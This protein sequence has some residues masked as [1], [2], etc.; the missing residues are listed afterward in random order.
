[1][2]TGSGEVSPYFYLGVDDMT[3]TIL[4]VDDESKV[5]SAFSRD[6]FELDICNVLTAPNGGVGLEMV[7]ENP[8]IAAVFSDFHMPGLD[9]VTF[10]SEVRKLNPDITRVIITGAAGLNM[11]L[12]AINIGQIFRILLKPTETDVFIQTV[13]DAIR[14]YQLITSEKVL[15]NK[16]LNGAVKTLVDVLSL[17]SPEVFAQGNRLRE[18]AKKMARYFPDELGWEAELSALL[19]QIGCVTVPRE[20]L[21]R[22]LNG[23]NLPLME[24]EMIKSIPE[25]GKQ[26]IENIP[27][28]EK[29]A[30]A[31][32]NQNVPYQNSL[33]IGSKIYHPVSRI[34]YLLNLLLQYD[35]NLVR[36]KDPVNAFTALDKKID[37]FDPELFKVFREKVIGLDDLLNSGKYKLLPQQEE[38]KVIDLR[39]GAVLAKEIMDKDGHMVVAKGTEITEVLKMR[40]INFSLTHRINPSAWIYTK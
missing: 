37:E 19:C 18:M 10:L 17:F 29:V 11:A 28:M 12:D 40:L 30:E 34:A 36:Y 2:H 22:W 25:S 15:L 7:R 20:I 32:K 14:Q 9:G 23:E 8:E 16:T 27:R 38:V 6:I 31:I 39:I 26:L 13:Q 1:V 24:Q 35:Q 5:L 4:L 33:Q 21:D 3:E